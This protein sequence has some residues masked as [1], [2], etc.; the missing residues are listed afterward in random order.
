MEEYI[1]KFFCSSCK[2]KV[3]CDKNGHMW[4]E[5]KDERWYA[6]LQMLNSDR[7]EP[8]PLEEIQNKLEGK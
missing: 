5:C 3:K 4:C 2:T 7:W 8:D 6:G 1:T